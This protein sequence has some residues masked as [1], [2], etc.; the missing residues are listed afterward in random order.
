MFLDTLTDENFLLYASRSYYNPTAFTIDEF[1]DDLLRFKYVKR[2]LNRYSETGNIQ[3][4]LL[5]N[6]ITIICNVF[7]VTNGIKMLM[8]KL[9]EQHYPVLRTLLLYLGYITEEEFTECGIDV[10]IAEQ[11]KEV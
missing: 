10:I 8:F 2:L 1:N 9:D 4:R 6:H 11:L 7:S 3:L 5:L